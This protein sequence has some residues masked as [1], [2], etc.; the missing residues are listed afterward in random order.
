MPVEY[1]LKV[2]I[3]G[4]P[5]ELKTDWV[6]RY[7]EG[8][9]TTDYLPILGV[10]ITTKQIH[11]NCNNVKLILVDTASQEFFGKVRPSYY[12]GAS[13]AIITFDKGD[14]D[15]FNAVKKYYNEFEKYIPHGSI[16]IT[17]VGFI[18]KSESKA[19]TSFF[20]KIQKQLK[21]IRKWIDWFNNDEIYEE[22]TS[23]EG[24]S[25]AEELGASYCETQPTLGENAIESIFHNLVLQ[26]LRR[27]SPHE[28]HKEL[29]GN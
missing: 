19:S 18:T 12:R 10:D 24:Q 25:L 27:N 11:V 26:V 5:E 13:A 2:C 14:R 16:P 28:D 29:G 6:R 1:L 21:K 23:D 9:F 7:A 8:K 4:F 15:S 22:I 20:L 3:L 17:L